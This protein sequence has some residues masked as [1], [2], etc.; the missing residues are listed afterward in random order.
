LVATS[1]FSFVP[2]RSSC[3]NDNNN[4][5]GDHSIRKSITQEPIVINM[6]PMKR[7]LTDDPLEFFNTLPSGIKLKIYRF[8]IHVF[9]SRQEL[10]EAVELYVHT[11]YGSP[12]FHSARWPHRPIDEWDVSRVTDFSRVLSRSR[13]ASAGRFDPDLSCWDVSNGTNF[14][15]MFWGCKY[16]NGD[17]SKW[18]V[19]KA[20][21]L[22]G[23]FQGCDLF[24]VDVSNW[25]VS[26]VTDL[27]RMFYDCRSFNADLS[28]WNVS[29]ATRLH[30][31]FYN[32][33]S[34]NADLSRWNISN[35]TDLHCMFYNCQS[36]HADLSQWNVLNATNLCYMFSGCSSFNETFVAGWPLS[37]SRRQ[38]LLADMR[39]HDYDDT[40]SSRTDTDDE[41]EKSIQSVFDDSDFD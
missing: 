8:T 9:D 10:I 15:R 30:S 25:N 17:V 3:A 4:E 13:N 31:M 23:M 19:S 39:V 7:K 27:R 18:N 40:S 26:N 5:V 16:F 29:N 33:Q 1:Q 36:F 21:H 11:I 14:V 34:F 37:P 24:N 20:T 41:D 22:Q 28:R 38:F 6:P 35:A 12:R 32:C 2:A